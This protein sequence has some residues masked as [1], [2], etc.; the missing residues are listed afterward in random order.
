M[1]SLNGGDDLAPVLDRI[2]DAGGSVILG[3]TEISPE[4]GYFAP[5]M[6]SEGNRPGLHFPH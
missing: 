6:D 4:I 5:F 3:K 1:I 2:A